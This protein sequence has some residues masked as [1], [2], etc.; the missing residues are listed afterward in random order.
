MFHEILDSAAYGTSRGSGGL[1]WTDDGLR[2]AQ[3]H[4][5]F[6]VP[7]ALAAEITERIRALEADP[8]R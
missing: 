5:T 7:N 6:P 1:V 3:Y 4:L 2:I 8:G